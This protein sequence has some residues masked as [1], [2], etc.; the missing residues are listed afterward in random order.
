MT[1]YLFMNLRHALIRNLNL[2]QVITGY[3]LAGSLIGPGGL[4]FVSEMVQ[5]RCFCFLKTEANIFAL[6][7]IIS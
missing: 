6:F 1:V 4:N 7:S 3:L 5:V 2:S